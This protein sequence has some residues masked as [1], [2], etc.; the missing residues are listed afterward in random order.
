MI[1]VMINTITETKNKVKI[2]NPI[3]LTM[4]LNIELPSLAM[5]LRGYLNDDPNKKTDPSYRVGLF[6]NCFEFCR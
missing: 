2:D 5:V 4:N 1:D 3:R 6:T